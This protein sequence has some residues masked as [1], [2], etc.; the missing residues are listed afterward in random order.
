MSYGFTALEKMLNIAA[1]L[2]G[3]VFEAFPKEP[4]MRIKPK[5]FLAMLRM[6]LGLDIQ[7]IRKGWCESCKTSIDG[8]GYHLS[9]GCPCGG[10]RQRVHT[11]FE[12]VLA[13]CCVDMGLHVKKES[14]S[15][16]RTANDEINKR[17]DLTVS[18]AGGRPVEVD[19]TITDC[20]ISTNLRVNADKILPEA[21]ARQREKEKIVKYN[22][23]AMNANSLFVPAVVEN[24]GRWGPLFRKFFKK[25]IGLGSIFSD[26]PQSYLTRYWG[27]RISVA[28][29]VEAMTQLAAAARSAHQK[30]KNTWAESTSPHSSDIWDYANHHAGPFLDED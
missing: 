27:H 24:H 2:I 6:H 17:P 7:F 25:I 10:Y 12:N 9:R 29:Q 5:L 20:R 23:L 16:L 19:V 21:A 14:S 15:N 3:H 4:L 13:E 28:I 22:E 30:G 26:M 11:A 18:N 8:A 1:V